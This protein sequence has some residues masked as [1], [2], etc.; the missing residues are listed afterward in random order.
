MKFAPQTPGEKKLTMKVTPKDGEMVVT[1]NEMSTFISVLSGGLNVLFLQG[2]NSTWDYLYLGRSIMRSTAIQMDG[3]A[4][5]RPAGRRARSMTRISPRQVQRIR[6]LE[7]GGELSDA[8][9]ACR[10]G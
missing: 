7:P 4:I 5:R 9:A 1:N 8:Q 3:I 6:V 10:S 2:Q